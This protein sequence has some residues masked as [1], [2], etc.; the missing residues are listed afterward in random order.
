MS[1]VEVDV[2]V[3]GGGP[4][5]LAA[6]LVSAR[7]GLRVRL[8]EA[9][10]H[11]G[12]MAG[13]FEVAGQRVDFGS[14][15][16]HP[17]AGP[18]VRSLL[19]ELL[20]N[21]LQIRE[22]NGR[23]RLRNRWVAFPF[24]PPDLIA[25]LPLS[26]VVSAAVDTVGRPLRRQSSDS[27]AEI[28]RVGLGRTAL[29]DFHGPMAT[30]LWGVPPEQLSGELARKRLPVRS[31]SVLA[32][33]IARS[34]R[35]QGRTFLYPRRGFGQIVDRFAEAAVDS[36]AVVETGRR[37][38]EVDPGEDSTL[39]WLDS[40]GPVRARRVLWTAPPSALATAIGNSLHV[41]GSLEVAQR[42]LVLAYLVVPSTT[43]TSFD[44]HYVPDPAV[45]FSRLSEPRNY[46][47][48]PDPAGQTVLCAEVPCTAG[49]ATWSADADAIA[50][51]VLDGLGRC[52]LP[53]PEVIHTQLRHLPSVYPL[54]SIH[55]AEQ[56]RTV[57]EWSETVP[58]VT[59]LGR[60]GRVVAD[61]LHH[62]LD[63]A[64]SAVDCLDRNASWDSQAWRAA[65]ER[66]ET[67]VV[68]D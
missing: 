26:F 42:G 22:R 60:Q 21:D 46:R 35:P 11:L 24:R 68:E 44:A 40:G 38:T 16:L 45:A 67:F 65:S 30:K 18:R 36:G 34:A 59:V 31:A 20:G 37:I 52:G 54:V 6:A 12:G 17:A 41:P 5:G 63:M 62:V 13:S 32:R 4:A 3:V 15:R 50:A 66:F 48:G 29:T 8:V 64:L 25:S 7:R 9:S 1:D 2:L 57:L 43:Y 56:R 49:D 61:N 58:G 23:L 47:D 10:P 19:D 28:V 39:V 55:D 14:H 51:S 33:K 27:Y 53:R